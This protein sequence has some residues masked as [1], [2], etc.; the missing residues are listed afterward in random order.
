MVPACV[1]KG[2]GFTL[3]TPSLLIDGLLEMPLKIRPLPAIG[4]ARAIT[5]VARENELGNLPVEF[6]KL[7]R[8]GLVDAVHRHLRRVGA[9]A[10]RTEDP[11]QSAGSQI[12]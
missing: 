8:Q 9:D 5:V 6:A 3:L 7:A 11:S 12:A 4:L 2:K 1:A 10:V